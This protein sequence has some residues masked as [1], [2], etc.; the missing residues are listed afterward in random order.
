[1]AFPTGR[2][3]TQGVSC[4]RASTGSCR[5][6]PGQQGRGEAGGG[7]VLPEREGEQVSFPREGPARDVSW[8]PGQRRPPS[9]R[10]T[11]RPAGN[12]P[13]P[14]A[15][16]PAPSDPQE[17]ELQRR[18][19]LPGPAVRTPRTPCCRGRDVKERSSHS[20][21]GL[22]EFLSLK[23]RSAQRLG[24][25]REPP[26]K[27]PESPCP[28]Q[29]AG[30]LAVVLTAPAAATRTHTHLPTGGRSHVTLKAQKFARR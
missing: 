20:P 30:L 18:V 26:E 25:T 6:G 13:A 28:G 23:L 7:V 17:K 1:M 19:P 2:P 4:P 22:A 24:V 3:H 29:A 12:K 21:Q 8:T 10:P 15:S 11:A 9:L 5:R 16:G 27:K 14:R